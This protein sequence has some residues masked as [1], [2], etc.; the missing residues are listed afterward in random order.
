MHVCR[1]TASC[2]CVLHVLC[3]TLLAHLAP[4]PVQTMLA[5]ALPAGTVRLGRRLVSIAE[6][7]A[8]VNLI[9]DDGA[10]ELVDTHVLAVP[11]LARLAS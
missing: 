3:C 5:D 6:D 4:T 8:G 2:A 9:F 7:D 1:T 10:R 11:Q